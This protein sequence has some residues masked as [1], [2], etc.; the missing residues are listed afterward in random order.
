M[1]KFLGNVGFW[2]LVAFLFI[3]VPV[4]CVIIRIHSSFDNIVGFLTRIGS[5]NWF[6]GLLI[7]PFAALAIIQIIRGAISL[8]QTDADIF[9]LH[10]SKLDWKVSLYVIINFLGY[11]ALFILLKRIL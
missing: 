2:A 4:V 9:N 8:S 5:G 7:V 11:A 6:V 1:K 10:D 3:I